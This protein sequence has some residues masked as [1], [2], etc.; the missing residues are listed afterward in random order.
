ME[1]KIE[2]EMAGEIEIEIE[3]DL[4][5]EIDVQ[6]EIDREIQIEIARRHNYKSPGVPKT[7]FTSGWRVSHFT[8]RRPLHTHRINGLVRP[9]PLLSARRLGQ[10]RLTHSSIPLHNV[11]KKVKLFFTLRMSS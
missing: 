6:V 11:F 1:V 8:A 10:P 3:V 2:V 4:V 5:V 7:S 9:C